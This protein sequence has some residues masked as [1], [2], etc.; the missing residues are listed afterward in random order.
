MAK[1]QRQ[2]DEEIDAVK[3]MNQMQLYAKVVTIRDKQLE[4]NKVLEQKWKDEQMKLDLMMEVERLKTLKAI[5]EREAE[6]KETIKKGALV[7]VDQMRHNEGL[8][9]KEKEAIAKEQQ[10]ILKNIEVMK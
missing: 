6:I 7:I 4:E 2:L 10:E 8:R 9:R 5:E 1:A 3:N